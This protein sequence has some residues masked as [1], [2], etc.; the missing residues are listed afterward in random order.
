MGSVQVERKSES[1][2]KVGDKYGLSAT[3]VTR[4]IRLATLI[5]ELLTFVDSGE[6]AFNAAYQL[7]FI[8]DKN[9]QIRLAEL[10]GSGCK[11][12]MKK[13]N[14]L[15]KNYADGVLNSAKI[16]RILSR[17][18]P[19]TRKSFSLDAKI[20]ERFFDESANK[21]VVEMT[22]ATALQFYWDNAGGGVADES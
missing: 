16:E 2:E 4:Y 11:I 20:I 9:L 19:A 7:S 8:E 17:E 1:R 18:N 22:I 6:I 10:V 12:D 14:F 15:R 5:P 21:K 3:N 13:A